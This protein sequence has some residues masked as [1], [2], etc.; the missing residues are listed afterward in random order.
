[1]FKKECMGKT[2]V[3]TTGH[4]MTWEDVANVYEK[5][6]GL[7]VEWVPREE[8][9]ERFGTFKFPLEYDRAYNRDADAT[10]ILEGSGLKLE[11]FTQFEDG[12]K[13]ELIKMGALNN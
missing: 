2:Y 8:Y 5:Y 7:K 3:L 11:D 1:M 10:E 6:L 9:L 12:V 4:R 13:S